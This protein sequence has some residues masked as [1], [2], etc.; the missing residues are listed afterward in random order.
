[1]HLPW[2]C[3]RCGRDNHHYGACVC[4]SKPLDP[5]DAKIESYAKVIAALREALREIVDEA[6]DLGHRD[7]VILTRMRQCAIDA[8]A[9]YE[10]TAGVK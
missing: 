1:M 4:A 7:G 3:D 5:K 6:N 8:L 10:Q 2:H 9:T